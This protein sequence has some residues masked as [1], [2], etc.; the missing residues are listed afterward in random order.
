MVGNLLWGARHQD[1]PA[2]VAAFR[3]EIDDPV[4]AT[5][6]IEV[7]LDHQKIAVSIKDLKEK[8]YR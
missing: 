4:G 8:F 3:T 6:H 5:D 2:L 7:V 1:L